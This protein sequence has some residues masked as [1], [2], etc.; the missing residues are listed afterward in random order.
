MEIKPGFGAVVGLAVVG[1]GAYVVYRAYGAASDAADTLDR[2]KR[3]A[4]KTVSDALDSVGSGIATAA[5]AV[6]P[7]SANNLAYRGTNAAL[8]AW[9]GEPTY[10]SDILFSLLNQSARAA[11]QDMLNPQPQ[12]T[13]WD[14]EDQEA[15]LAMRAATVTPGGAY[16]GYGN[17]FKVKRRG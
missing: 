1:L 9:T 13:V 6:N 2:I 17:S 7:T 15:G 12:L 16:I 4:W 10:A 5:D 11:E 8:T 3:E 14:I